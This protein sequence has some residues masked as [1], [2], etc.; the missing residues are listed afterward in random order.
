MTGEASWGVYSD[1]NHVCGRSPDLGEPFVNK[2]FCSA[3]IDLMQILHSRIVQLNSDGFPRLVG[4]L[5]MTVISIL[6]EY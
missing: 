3:Q 5:L 6:N 1:S 4:N 2:I